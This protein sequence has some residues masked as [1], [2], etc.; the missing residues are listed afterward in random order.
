MEQKIKNLIKYSL[1]NLDIEVNNIG[2]EHPSDSKM[3]D[4]STNVAMVVA[5]NVKTNPK[6]LADKIKQELDKKLPK[7]VEKIEVAGAGFINFYL[8]R[9][10]FAKS[11]EEIL[12]NAENVGK[13]DMLADKKIMIEYT[14]PNPFK[15]FHIGHLMSN[16]IGESISRLVEFSGAK[17]T[18]ANSQG[19]QGFNAAKATQ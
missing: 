16:E 7:E 1:K 10:F 17:M 8:S 18:R 15:P 5:K 4:Y 9:D 14:D 19:D 3:G 11:I 2:L 13:N 12:N 6:E